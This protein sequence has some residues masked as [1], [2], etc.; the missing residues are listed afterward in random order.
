[1][2]CPHLF[3]NHARELCCCVSVFFLSAV[4][5]VTQF[6]RIEILFFRRFIKDEFVGKKTKTNIRTV[7]HVRKFCFSFYHPLYFFRWFSYLLFFL[8]VWEKR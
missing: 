4:G 1:M 8:T 2:M 7:L 6:S 5:D 3:V